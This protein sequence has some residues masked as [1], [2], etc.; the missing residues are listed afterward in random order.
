MIA[1]ATTTGFQ[2][3]A[4]L[5]DLF[6]VFAFG[7]GAI[8]GCLKTPGARLRNI[9]PPE[10]LA[11]FKNF[12]LD[13]RG[14]TPVIVRPG[15][16]GRPWQDLAA[17]VEAVLGTPCY[18]SLADVCRTLPQRG[19]CST[20]AFENAAAALGGVRLGSLQA[21]MAY[22]CCGAIERHHRNDG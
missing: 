11:S 1:S 15:R 17:D 21:A 18:V 22:V 6:V 16:P 2:S 10:Q 3:V 13:Y 19:L 20:I 5:S 14:A 4:E 9:S 8:G 12:L 7:A